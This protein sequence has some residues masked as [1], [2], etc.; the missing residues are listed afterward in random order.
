MH[1]LKIVSIILVIAGTI[2]FVAGLILLYFGNPPY[3]TVSAL[4]IIG[5]LFILGAIIM[6][7]V[8]QEYDQK[9]PVEQVEER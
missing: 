2:I 9:S 3:G 7:C 4:L 6:L 5:L 1:W 8:A